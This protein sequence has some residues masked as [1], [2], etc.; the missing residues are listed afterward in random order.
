MPQ[1]RDF[2]DESPDNTEDFVDF[3]VDKYIGE[4]L[5]EN[6]MLLKKL[7]RHVSWDDLEKLKFMVD[8]DPNLN[9]FS[10][11]L[12][13]S[14]RPDES[15]NIK[16]NSES[17]LEEFPRP[18]I[19]VD[20]A[21]LSVIEINN[22]HFLVALANQR[23]PGH[24]EGSWALPGR[25]LRER[26]TLEKTALDAVALKLGIN[27]IH[28]DQLRVFDDP[29][30]DPRGWVLSVAHLATVP[31]RIAREALSRRD[32]API[33]IDA[34]GVTLPNDQ[35]DLPYEQ[36]KILREAVKE[37]RRRYALLPD[38]GYILD[39]DFTLLQLREIHQAVHDDEIAPDTFRR[40][41]L[42]NL[43]ATGHRQ[44]GVVGKP[45]MMYQRK[46]RDA[47]KVRTSRFISS[48]LIDADEVL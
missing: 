47:S 13:S 7:G 46:E 26:E 37:L 20:V 3:F 33:I 14:I 30:R 10:M 29:H 9:F 19:A 15:E 31:S 2:S 42:P 40:E 28:V 17:D 18:S 23:G 12:K 8:I 25:M 24:E 11:D 34:D 22:R 45:P 39:A 41:M 35:T 1:N 48:K 44:E 5:L 6:K 27:D 32:V 43:K 4:N 16:G 38:P 36:M 21:V